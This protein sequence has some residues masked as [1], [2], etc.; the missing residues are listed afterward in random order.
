MNIKAIK[1]RKFLPPQDR[2]E[3]L[4]EVLP[5]LK[6]NSIVAITS[7]V[8]SITEGRCIKLSEYPEKDILVAKEADIYLSRDLVPNKWVMHTIKNNLLIPSSGI[9]ESNGDGY[10]I[11]WPKDSKKSAKKIWEY[12]TQKHNIKNLGVII[13]DSHSIPLRR[14]LVGISLGHFGFGPLRDY[15][16]DEDL[17]GRNLIFSMTN[18]ADSLASAAVFVMGEGKEQTP[19]ALIEDLNGVE[20]I[21]GNKTL[22]GADSDFEIEINKDL[23]AP[24]LKSVPWKKS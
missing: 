19:I 22:T 13:T 1:T 23:Y 17:F 9:D 14:G 5:S 11:L 4:L 21:N 15:R 20:F 10:Y 3:D 12:L 2:L 18:I 6:E 8:V 7:K 16:Q 24:F